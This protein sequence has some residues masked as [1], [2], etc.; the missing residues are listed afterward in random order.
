MFCPRNWCQK[1]WILCVCIFTLS[2]CKVGLFCLCWGEGKTQSQK[3]NKLALPQTLPLVFSSYTKNDDII[4]YG[5]IHK[6]TWREEK[7]F[8]V[9]V[10][11]GDSFV[12]DCHNTWTTVSAFLRWLR[13]VLKHLKHPPNDSEAALGFILS[14]RRMGSDTTVIKLGITDH[15]I[16]VKT[17]KESSLLLFS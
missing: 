15:W 6:K 10:C 1:Y 13:V 11:V 4:S 9:S 3:P 14:S 2:N 16:Y 7:E 5:K 12:K 17:L 8:L